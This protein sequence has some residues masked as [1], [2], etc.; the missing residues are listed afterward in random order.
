MHFDTDLAMAFGGA[1]TFDEV[2][3]FALADF[4]VL[5]GVDRRLMRREAQ[6][7][8]GAANRA[9]AELA[10]ANEYR[11]DERE[12]VATLASFVGRQA[13]RL[14]ELARAAAEIPAGLL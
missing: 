11:D 13:Q 8:A 7:L 4:A 5:C 2:K 3:A 6:R 12:F 14:T 10:H 1:F 9:A